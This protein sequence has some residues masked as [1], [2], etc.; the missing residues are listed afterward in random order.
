MSKFCKT[1]L[2]GMQEV[3]DQF[4]RQYGKMWIRTRSN[5]FGKEKKF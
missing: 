2:D 4:V 1:H 5:N 3:F